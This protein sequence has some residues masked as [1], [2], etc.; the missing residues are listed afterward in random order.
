MRTRYF[1]LVWGIV[2]CNIYGAITF[3]ASLGPVLDEFLRQHFIKAKAIPNMPIKSNKPYL[4]IHD[5]PPKTGTTT[6][7]YA[8]SRMNEGGI[9]AKDNYTYQQ[10]YLKKN[11]CEPYESILSIPVIEAM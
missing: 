8:F 9:L 1:Y 2:V 11:W 5:G 6:L 10:A 7:Q 3:S 4:V